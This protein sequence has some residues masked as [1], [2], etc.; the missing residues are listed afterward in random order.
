M[1]G[2]VG[3]EVLVAADPRWRTI[4]REL[5]DWSSFACGIS[6]DAHYMRMLKEGLI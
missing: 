1:G 2:E 6:F 3:P 5:G 4:G